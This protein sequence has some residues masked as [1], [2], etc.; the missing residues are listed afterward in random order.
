MEAV[1]SASMA[2]APQPL[3]LDVS[4]LVACRDMQAVG[5]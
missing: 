4:F 3:L 1:D 2:E 5:N